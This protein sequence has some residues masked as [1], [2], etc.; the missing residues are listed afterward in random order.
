ML[1]LY[2]VACQSKQTETMVLLDEKISEVKISKS[3]G[4]GRMNEDVIV[5]FKDKES[6]D[7]FGNAIT[8]AIKQPEKRIYTFCYV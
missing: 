2:I 1:Q 4:F 6:L 8:T 5:S 7:I 3:K